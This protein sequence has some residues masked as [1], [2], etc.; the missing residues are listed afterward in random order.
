MK[1]TRRA[2]NTIIRILKRDVK[3]SMRARMFKFKFK[4]KC[5]VVKIFYLTCLLE[6][7]IKAARSTQI[8][9]K[10]RGV[11]NPFALRVGTSPSRSC[12]K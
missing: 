9:I 7:Y 8:I 11:I 12:A 5:V 4:F 6:I 10:M 3:R 2:K 1:N